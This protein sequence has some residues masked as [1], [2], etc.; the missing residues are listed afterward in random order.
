MDRAK[1]TRVTLDRHV[2]RRIGKHY[3][4]ALRAHQRGKCLGIESVA[5][6]DP[7]TPQ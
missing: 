2:V 7:M 6:Q 4:G 1:P 5:A 3:R